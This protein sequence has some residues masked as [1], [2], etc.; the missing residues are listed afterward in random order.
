V[1]IPGGAFHVSW[2]KSTAQLTLRSSVSAVGGNRTWGDPKD[3]GI[4]KLLTLLRMLMVWCSQ[5][6][7]WASGPLEGS[8]LRNFEEGGV[9]I[10]ERPTKRLSAGHRREKLF[11]RYFF[12]TILLVDAVS[13]CRNAVRAWTLDLSQGMSILR[14]R[15]PV[16]ISAPYR[17]LRLLT[18]LRISEKYPQKGV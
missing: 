15:H 3:S 7:F 14:A 16:I 18:L 6:R 1:E 13:G 8:L 17:L 12:S 2:P 4:R 5:K 10:T 11:D 9:L